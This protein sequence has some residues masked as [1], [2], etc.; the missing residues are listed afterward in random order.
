VVA[1]ASYQAFAD[2]ILKKLILEIAAKE[3]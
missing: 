2:A 3:R 1:A